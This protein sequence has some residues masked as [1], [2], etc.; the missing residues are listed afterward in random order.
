M[1]NPFKTLILI[2]LT[3]L[4]VS[5]AYAQQNDEVYS[6]GDF[7]YTTKRNNRQEEPVTKTDEYDADSIS[8]PE[9]S[10]TTAIIM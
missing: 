8:R 5:S 10:V 6:D 2:M 3:V 1:K 9:A 7:G 4:S